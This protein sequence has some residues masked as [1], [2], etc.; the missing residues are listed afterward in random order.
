MWKKVLRKNRKIAFLIIIYRILLDLVYV[1]IINQH[2]LYS[3]FLNEASFKSTFVSVIELIVYMPLF[4]RYFKRDGFANYTVLLLGLIYFIPGTSLMCFMPMSMGMLLAW[5]IFWASLLFFGIQN[6]KIQLPK[7]LFGHCKIYGYMIVLIFCITVL[8]ISYKYTGFRFLITFTDEYSLRAEQR[9]YEIGTILNYIYSMSSMVISLMICICCVWKKYLIAI[10]LL[11]VQVFNFSIGGHKTYLLFAV[12]AILMGCLYQKFYNK[13]K[14][15]ILLYGLI[16]VLLMELTEYLFHHTFYLTANISRRVLFV[17]QILNYYYYDFFSKNEFDYFRQGPL[18][19][20]GIQSAY[21]KGISLIIGEIYVGENCNACNG[22]FSEA[23]SNMGIIGV[24]ILPIILLIIL[25][26]VE[27][28]VKEID[29]SVLVFLA[30][31]C[32]YIFGSGNISTG[33]LSNG[34]IICVVLCM[35]LKGKRNVTDG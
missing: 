22:L 25:R 26:I 3:G 2:Y 5:N 7:I 9:S 20:L 16:A 19:L 31:T 30:F 27:Y 32:S 21:E 4:F 8:Y 10:T 33:L 34:I 23:Y 24:M 28:M 11:I 14:D 1:N 12:L 35:V 17:P 15:L 6:F 18:R 13:I 29:R